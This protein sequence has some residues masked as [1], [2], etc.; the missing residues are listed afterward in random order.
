MK[1]ISFFE[2][3]VEKIVVGV[4]A[5]GLVTVAGMELLSGR[6]VKSGSVELTPS[7]VNEVLDAR[8]KAIEGGLSDGSARIKL[9]DKPLPLVAAEFTERLAKPLASAA[10]LPRIAPSLAG[11]LMDSDVLT[12]TWYYEPKLAAVRMGPDVMQTSDAIPASVLTDKEHEGLAAY[13]PDAGS[14]A[15]VDVTWLTPWATL[16]LKALKAELRRADQDAKPPRAAVPTAW[17]NEGTYIVDV[18]FEREE[19]QPGGAWGKRTVV[20]PLPG[21]LTYRP[22]LGAADLTLRDQVMRQLASPARQLEILQPAF[23]DTRND[24]FIQPGSAPEAGAAN[25]AEA[26]EIMKVRRRLDDVVRDIAKTDEKLKEAGGPLEPD[27]LRKKDK[28]QNKGGAGAPAGGGGGFGGAGGPAGGSGGSGGSGS[29]GGS[30]G[31][32]KRGGGGGNVPPPGGGGLGGG[33]GGGVMGPPPG[34]GAGAGDDSKKELR[35]RLTRKLKELKETAARY[36]KDLDAKAP[37]AAPKE[38]EKTPTVT[39]INREDTIPIWAHDL[40]VKP[41][42]TYRYRCIVQVYNP[43]FGRKRQLVP[44]QVGLSDAFVLASEASGWSNPVQVTPPFIFFVTG[45]AAEGGSLDL[46]TAEVEVYRLIEGVRKRQQFTVQPGDRIGRVVTPRK[47]EGGAP[48]DFTTDWYV[49]A[50]VEDLAG[51]RG[52]ADRQRPAFVLVRRAGQDERLELRVP[53]TDSENADRRRLQDEAALAP[54]AAAPPEKTGA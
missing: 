52:P 30:G 51:D 44:Q 6:S 11:S 53:V 31:N 29:G 23:Y 15:A 21:H 10:P 16:D 49:L 35:L 13:F 34:S 18:L 47:T 9:D 45:A 36:Q 42:S 43:F 5:L 14:A 48:V 32:G 24:S 17:F 25:L 20:K 2:Q 7:N 19:L 26:R 3:H 41:E 54:T 37:A 28:D 38:G 46:G 12:D 27:D 33:G 40:D 4:A 22:R 1:G 39:D 8:A 50:I